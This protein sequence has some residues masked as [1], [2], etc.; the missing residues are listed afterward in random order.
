[1][2]G[3]FLGLSVSAGQGPRTPNLVSISPATGLAMGGTPM[4][5]SGGRF[6]GATGV[7]VGGTACTSVVVVSDSSVTCVAPLKAAGVYDVAITTPNGTS[8]LA[9]AY[10]ADVTE[11]VAAIVGANPTALWIPGIYATDRVGGD[12]AVSAVK[13]RMQGTT[14]QWVA[15]AAAPWSATG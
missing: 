15:G 2:P 8:T 11:G 1:M 4:T 7:T 5:L 14:Y 13:D 3:L 10:T 6:T 12:A 9:A